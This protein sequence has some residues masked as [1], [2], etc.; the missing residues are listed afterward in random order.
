M[1]FIAEPNGKHLFGSLALILGNASAIPISNGADASQYLRYVALEMGRF[2]GPMIAIVAIGELPRHLL[3]TPHRW[4]LNAF[5]QTYN[6]Y[7]LEKDGNGYLDFPVWE[8]PQRAALR[9]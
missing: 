2:L 1:A 4:S 8:K 5:F 9:L 6:A 3:R 7:P